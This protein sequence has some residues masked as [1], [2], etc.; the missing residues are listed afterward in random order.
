[1]RVLMLIFL[2][3]VV[4]VGCSAS[5]NEQSNKTIK[6]IQD[7]LKTKPKKANK[8]LGEIEAY[9][10]FGYEIEK[11]SQNNVILKNGSKTYILFYNQ[12]EDEQSDVVYKSTLNQHKK[13][14][15]NKHW[16]NEDQ[17]SYLLIDNYEKDMNELIVGIG[18]VK[19][20]SEVKTSSLSTEAVQMMEIVQSVKVKSKE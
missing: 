14:D 18:G 12:H 7:Q 2:S 13:I 19:L 10:P 17:F 3:F 16:K 20:T 15:T 8:N 9:L 1:M 5:L 6:T 4:L 11:I